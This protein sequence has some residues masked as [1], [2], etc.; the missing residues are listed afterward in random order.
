M[1]N[2][3]RGFA[4][5]IAVLFSTSTFAQVETPV[6]W[7]LS[8]VK[9]SDCEY[10]L[11]FSATIDEHWH[12]YSLNQKGDDGP[13]PSSIR[14]DKSPDYE[15]VGKPTEGKPIKIFDKVFEM[16]VLYFEKSL[17]FKQR[18]RLKTDKEITVKGSY[19]YETCTDEKCT[20]PPATPFDFKLKGTAECLKA[21]ANAPGTKT[22]STPCLV[23]SAAI[24]KEYAV[25]HS[26]TIITGNANGKNDTA[27]AGGFSTNTVHGTNEPLPGNGNPTSDKDPWW[28][29]FLIGFGW[30][31]AAL[32]TP[33]V[34]PLI[35]MNVSF[36]LKRS[37]SKAKGR[38]NALV[39]AISIIVIF[40]VLGLSISLIFGAG[41]LNT[42]ST[43]APFNLILFAL[44]LIF[45]ASFLGAFEIVLPSRFV[46]KID[47]QGDR[48]GFA[49]IFFMAL[50]LVVVSFS[51]TG[52][53]IGNALVTA[54][55]T[56]EISG[57]FWAMF[58]FS[59]GLAIPFGFFAFF[60]A[61]LNSM[62][63]SGGWLNTVKV[64]LGFLE[65]A[66]ALKF[67]SNVDLVYQLGILT[68][69][70]F[71]VLWI[72]IFGLLT[73]YLLGGFKTSHDS[74]VKHISV[75]RLFFIIIT[76]SLTIYLIPG[77][78]GAPLKLFS[79]ILP[80]QEYS[81]SPH[82]FGGGN[83]ASAISSNMDKEFAAF[84]EVNKNGVVHFK[85]D[86]EHALAYAKKTG[87][88][89]MIDFT[90]HA[91]ANCRKTEDYIWPDPKVLKR[92]NN[93]VVLVSLYVD[94]KRPLDPK[95][96][97]KVFWYGQ[98]REITTIGDKFKYME[99]TLY[100]QSSQPLYVLVDHSEQLLNSPRGYKSGIPE[101][102]QWLDEGISEFKKRTNK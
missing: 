24:A 11:V 43:S 82:G 47:A 98:E 34:F 84:I 77:L 96:Y 10:E 88:P 91:C 16:D 68:R 14:L 53:M 101:Y 6:K 12:V 56:G 95:D 27:H 21:A 44:L 17:I 74:D 42:L 49:G 8:T 76:F 4:V 50:A 52:V 32:L 64:T 46:N 81:E 70:V 38:F 18:I 75:S 66:L 86:Y 35:P 89:L 85:N 29:I 26:Q 59:T 72:V 19:E 94:D 51:C 65:L 90:G 23:D 92:L 33:C 87:K 40:V 63:K 79:G 36:F 2:V 97:Q 99:E 80:P 48:G 22:E 15:A 37:T 5:L 62:P 60:P 61:M 39:Y 100:K 41:A 102:T 55:G 73:I 13:V 78:W 1:K 67:A 3:F 9:V 54:A 57:P 25:S 71:L 93:N 83:G 31:F 58:G 69:E 30:G 7:K 45:A 28:L 20:F